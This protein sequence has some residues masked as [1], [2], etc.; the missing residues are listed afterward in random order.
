[1]KENCFT[2]C[3]YEKKNFIGLLKGL[4]TKIVIVKKRRNYIQH[5]DKAL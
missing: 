4:K 3:D 5:H 2:A 1:M